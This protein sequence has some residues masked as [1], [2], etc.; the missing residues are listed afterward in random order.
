MLSETLFAPQAEHVDL[1]QYILQLI[2]HT[3]THSLV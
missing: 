1:L 3:C 2:I